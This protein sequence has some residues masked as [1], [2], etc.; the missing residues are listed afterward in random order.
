MSDIFTLLFPNADELANLIKSLA[1]SLISVYERGDAEYLAAFESAH[2][3]M[4]LDL[5]STSLR[6]NGVLQAGITSIDFNGKYHR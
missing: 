3:R 2:E 1:N 6:T 4:M 5:G